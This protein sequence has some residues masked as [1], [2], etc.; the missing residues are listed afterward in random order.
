MTK[1][2]ALLETVL[3]IITNGKGLWKDVL[4]KRK[5]TVGIVTV[6]VL[7][8][9][10]VA[11]SVYFITR[12]KPY[13]DSN[14]WKAMIWHCNE[15]EFGEGSV[16]SDTVLKLD[17]IDKGEVAFWCTIRTASQR[18]KKPIQTAGESLFLMR[19]RS[20]STECLQERANLFPVIFL[21]LNQ[22][23]TIWFLLSSTVPKET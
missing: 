14:D 15:V 20:N 3:S 23:P 5:K 8:I 21:K 1:V 12:P 9:A 11:I 19:I 2:L 17:V 4:P 13:F 7:L 22:E 16:S 18:M 6:C 10:I